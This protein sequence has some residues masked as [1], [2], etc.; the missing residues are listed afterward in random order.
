MTKFFKIENVY[1]VKLRIMGRAGQSAVSVS[2]CYSELPTILLI[3]CGWRGVRSA[4]AG[5]QGTT[6]DARSLIRQ[7]DP[8]LPLTSTSYTTTPLPPHHRAWTNTDQTDRQRKQTIHKYFVNKNKYIY[9]PAAN[10]VRLYCQKYQLRQILKP[11]KH[12]FLP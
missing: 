4:H 6:E 7:D 12:L 2:E 5:C 3:V 1:F 11:L 8:L 9:Q 10:S